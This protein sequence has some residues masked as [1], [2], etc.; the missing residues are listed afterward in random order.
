MKI[1]FIMGALRL[2]EWGETFVADLPYRGAGYVTVEVGAACE[3]GSV[4]LRGNGLEVD[5]S[6]YHR[7]E[8]AV[9]AE[10]LKVR[11]RIHVELS[12]IFGIEEDARV[13]IHGRPRVY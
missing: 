9:C 10:C 7:E 1:T 3:C 12:T 11:G 13:L 5:E 8:N 6:D 2:R 4:S